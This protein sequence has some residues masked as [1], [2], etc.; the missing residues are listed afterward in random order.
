MSDMI[1]AWGQFL[2]HDISITHPGSQRADID[3]LDPEDLL[4]PGPIHFTR[5]DWVEGM[6][7]REHVNDITAFIDASNVYG[8]SKDEVDKLRTGAGGKLI[9]S[10]G[11][12]LPFDEGLQ[13]FLAGDIRANEH[14]GL[15]SMHTLFVREH[16]RLCDRII[17]KYNA[18]PV[19]KDDDIF[20]LARKIVGAEMQI[21]TYNEFLPA[22]LGNA[23]PLPAWNGYDSSIDPR[24]STEFSTAFYRF[25]HT[26]LSPDLKVHLPNDMDGAFPLR[27]A[28]FTPLVLKNNPHMVDQFIHGFLHQ[29]AQEID[30]QVIDDVRDFLFGEPG[31]GGLDLASLNIQ[32]GRDHGLPT[33]GAILQHELMTPP[34]TYADVTSN[35]DLASRLQ[36]VYGND[37]KQLDP[38]IAGLAEDHLPGASVG[39]L[40]DYF[41]RDQFLRLRDGDPFYWENDP[42]LRGEDRAAGAGSRCKVLCIHAS[43]GRSAPCGSV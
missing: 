40:I 43:D 22:V 15:I 17:A 1:W 28:Y 29:N 35:A 37:P 11:D 10:S 20:D 19:T 38:W 41:L 23:N 6:S 3:V 33:Y 18:D 12:L 8:S 27:E 24:I 13:M 30:T 9:V 4:A 31:N 16:N 5:S 34:S 14:L 42:D 25:G 32:R 39:R 2:D 7:G 26:M 36:S 21:I